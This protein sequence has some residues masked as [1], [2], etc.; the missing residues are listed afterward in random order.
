NNAIAPQTTPNGG[1]IPASLTNLVTTAN[2]VTQVGVTFSGGWKANGILNG[3]L[4][5]PNPSLLGQFALPTATEDYLF[6]ES[7]GGTTGTASLTFTNLNPAR[8]YDLALFGTRNTPS[9]RNTQYT[10]VD[11]KNVTRSVTLQTSGAGSGSAAY[12]EGNDDTITMLT[13]LAP[14]ANGRL[15]LS[16]A[17]VNT[18]G[19]IYG[20]LGALQLTEGAT[21]VPAAL[22]DPIQRWIAQD[23]SDPITP[24]ALLFVG[25]STIR[26]WESL[27][28][29][30]ADYRVVQRGFGGSQFSEL[31]P[32]VDKIVTPYQPSAIVVWEGT[33]DIRVGNKTGETVFADF[34]AF[35]SAV[36]SQ[37]PNVPICYLGIVP[38][39]SFF[40]NPAHDPRR[41][42]ANSLIANYCASDAALNLHYIDTASFFEAL[43]DAGTPQGTMAW[44]S[45][46]VDDTHLNRAGYHEF[47][48]AVRPTVESLVAP[49]K[50]VDAG[51]AD[52]THGEMLLFDFGPSDS[53]AGD[54][55]VAVDSYGHHWNNWHP[56]NGLGLITSGE[57]LADLIKAD[58]AESGIR[59]TMTGGFQCNGKSGAGGLFNPSPARL[60]DLAVETATEDYFF[61]TADDIY[62]AGNDDVPGGFMLDGLNPALSYEFRFFGSR[63]TAETRVTEFAV[64][65]ANEKKVNLQT[66]GTGIGSSGGNGNDDEVAIVKG[67]RPDSFGQVFVDLTLLQGSFAYVNAMEIVVSSAAAGLPAWREGYF[68]TQELNDPE[69]EENYWGDQADPDADGKANV[70]EYASG[71]HPLLAELAETVEIGTDGT[72]LTLTYAKNL[73]A[74]D[75]RYSVQVS[76][77]LVDWIDVPDTAIGSDMGFQWRKASVSKTGFNQRFLRYLSSTT[78]RFPSSFLLPFSLT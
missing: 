47:L 76:G 70:F 77:D 19:N 52:F 30:F 5:N 73:V 55:T 75:L 16:V 32:V 59:M 68:T 45:H 71:G 29:D 28:R 62:G 25:S 57:H 69:L 49:N 35:V 9:I 78:L 54:A 46:F 64:Y 1:F 36:R 41:R 65:G 53:T 44:N 48:K 39:P 23:A 40:S 31:I 72:S 15:T 38:C 22:T 14:D 17:R 33:N 67:V 3:G 58:G 42:T 27:T 34:K 7:A 4:L 26:R 51:N 37:L 60:G 63:N 61:S 18:N 20:Y 43:H 10:V 74:M 56:T 24:G 11:G 21:I 8:A 66:S 50:P 6:V 13:G 2:V 12:P